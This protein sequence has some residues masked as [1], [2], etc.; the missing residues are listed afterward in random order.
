MLK[1]CNFIKHVDNHEYEFNK[2]LSS[3]GHGGT[4]EIYSQHGRSDLSPKNIHRIIHLDDIVYLRTLEMMN[5]TVNK[6]IPAV[7]R[8][9]V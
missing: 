1:R 2:I 7:I 8:K 9:S 4:S 5:R 6:K 3:R